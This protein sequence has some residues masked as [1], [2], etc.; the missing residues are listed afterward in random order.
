[1]S[2]PR[3]AAIIWTLGL[4]LAGCSKSRT[5]SAD[6]VGREVCAGCHVAEAKA[7]RGSHHDLAMQPAAD[8][9][10][11]GNFADATFTERGVTS[12][13]FRRDRGFWVS[14]SG[15]DGALR[16]Y[17]IAYTFGVDPLQQYLIA[18]PGGRYQ[19]LGIA[20]D[21]RP[22][23]QGGQRWFSLYPDTVLA[24][25]SRLHWTGVDQTWNHMCAE[26]HSTNVAKNFRP[27]TNSYGTTWS[28][29]N[30][31]CEAC[32]GPGSR[33]VR[34][35]KQNGLNGHRE[36]SGEAFGLTVTLRDR[37]F[38]AW[39]M[40][41][42]TGIVKRTVPLPSRT[43]VE[44][45]A[46]CHSRRGRIA[47][48]GV[49]GRTLL[50]THRP[51]LIEE[52]I[53]YPD[54]QILEEDYEYG[55]F[56]QSR[57]YKAGVTC[58]DCHDPHSLKPIAEG[59]AV[60]ARCHLPERFDTPRHHF[61]PAGSPG[62]ECV[63]CHMPQR[64]YMIVHAR[65]DHSMRVPRP[66]LS[67]TLHTPNACTNCHRDRSA[68]WAADA[69]LKWYGPR[70]RPEHYG[71]AFTALWNGA[72]GGESGMIAVAND[73]TLPPF[74]RASALAQ[75]R[76]VL[77][78][79]ATAAL[80]L[81]TQAADPLVRFG[82]VSALEGAGPEDRRSL[83]VPLLSDPARAVRLEAVRVLA[84]SSHNQATSLETALREYREAQEI[85]ADRPEAHFNLGNL[86][87]ARG[88][89]AGA[90]AEY[91]KSDALDSTFVPAT[92]NLADVLRA[93]G[94]DASALNVLRRG[95]AVTPQDP[96]LHHAL[97]LTLIRLR[98]PAEALPELERAVTLAPGN[99]RYVY[100]LAVAYHSTGQTDRAIDLLERSH[101]SRPGDRGVL[102]ALITI[103]R[104][105]GRSARALVHARELLA[106]DPEDAQ[107]RSVVEALE[108]G[109][110]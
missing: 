48:P 54:G 45:C 4:L 47:G 2:R 38:D 60:C 84:S 58:T 69:L 12:K 53:Y 16:E 63:A 37:K 95:L 70:P 22:S 42:G 107:A 44:T 49:T 41:P 64:T 100:V 67:V 18:F 80:R 59:N 91:R 26:C 34:W 30:V 14:T 7:W 39:T 51:S 35:A 83:A 86:A 5:P 82:A 108:A 77:G 50:D 96:S 104:D 28:E 72:A 85:D 87:L 79:K 17:P 13:F 56:L 68:V 9:T 61:H 89:T 88:D 6:Y 8:S 43:E 109:A 57:M 102:M 21:S 65:R 78:S 66:D 3:R 29:L 27:E 98:R 24:P 62:A 97:G 73:S 75:L 94:D 110:H 71:E 81:G 36:Q 74:V 52:G 10:V 11:L 23:G 93:R 33:H 76:D 40:D 46:P 90:E 55:S 106:L 101:T 15:P 31:S 99:A 1:M 25:G 32:H 20:W 105:A 19:C 92:M 103:E